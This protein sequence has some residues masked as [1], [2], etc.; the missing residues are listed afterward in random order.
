MAADAL[1]SARGL[2]F[3]RATEE[4][5]E[6]DIWEVFDKTAVSQRAHKVLVS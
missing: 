6:W 2:R 1:V 5:A 3:R 4:A